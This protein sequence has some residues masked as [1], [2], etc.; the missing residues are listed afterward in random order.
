MSRIEDTYTDEK[1]KKK[2]VPK[3]VDALKNNKTK[4]KTEEIGILII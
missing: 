2:M 4:S 3:Y 1:D